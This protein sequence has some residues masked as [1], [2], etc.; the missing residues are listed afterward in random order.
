VP[1]RALPNLVVPFKRPV[2]EGVLREFEP[3]VRT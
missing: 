3:F 2:Y 1:H